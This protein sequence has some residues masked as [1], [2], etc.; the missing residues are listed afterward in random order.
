[1]T[2]ERDVAKATMT[3]VA[4]TFPCNGWKEP[5]D[6][7]GP[8]GSKFSDTECVWNWDP[9]SD[10]SDD[11]DGYRFGRL[12]LECWGS[13]S[14]GPR[15][16]LSTRC[17][18]STAGNFRPKGRGRSVPKEDRSTPF[19]VSSC[20]FTKIGIGA[21]G[22]SCN[23]VGGRYLPLFLADQRRVG[24]GSLRLFP[25]PPKMW[26]RKCPDSDFCAAGKG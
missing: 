2:V 8:H 22:H 21:L 4:K 3:S 26:S 7:W 9:S 12:A 11:S 15:A 18:A 16:H 6:L 13:D 1:M 5:N 20:K 25:S 23:L 14:H 10:D 17:V 24:V 19:R